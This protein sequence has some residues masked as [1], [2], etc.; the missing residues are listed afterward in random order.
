MNNQFKENERVEIKGNYVLMSG[1]LIK[2]GWQ[3]TVTHYEGGCNGG[4]YWV[5]FDD[6]P[7]LVSIEGN[8]LKPFVH[9][10]GNPTIP[11]MPII[12]K[13]LPDLQKMSKECGGCNN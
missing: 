6:V 9:P 1:L 5:K 10:F 12:S 8:M 4:T 3:G 7:R 11:A 2:K 13:D